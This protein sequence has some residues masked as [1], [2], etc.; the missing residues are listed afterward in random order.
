MRLNKY[1]I[2]PIGGLRGPLCPVP[3][4]TL[5]NG[6]REAAGCDMGCTHAG[7]LPGTPERRDAETQ[8]RRNAARLTATLHAHRGEDEGRSE[9]RKRL[10]STLSTGSPDGYKPGCRATQAAAHGDVLRVG[11]P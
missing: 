9:R 6:K 8:K 5:H 7:V 10:F 2:R 3:Q 1:Q 11:R 4:V